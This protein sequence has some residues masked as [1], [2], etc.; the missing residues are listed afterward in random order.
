MVQIHPEWTKKCCAVLLGCISVS[1]DVGRGELKWHA[2]VIQFQK[3]KNS[4]ERVRL[5]IFDDRLLYQ[6]SP[7]IKGSCSFYSQHLYMHCEI[8]I[9]SF[10]AT[11]SAKSCTYNQSIKRYVEFWLYWECY[12]QNWTSI[13]LDHFFR[14]EELYGSN[15]ACLCCDTTCLSSDLSGKKCQVISEYVVVWM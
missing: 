6:L 12:F 15:D 8:S 1:W 13:N 3:K 11:P 2:D 5:M 10:K 4:N 7:L 14:W 9:G